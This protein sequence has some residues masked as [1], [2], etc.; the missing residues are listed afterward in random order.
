MKKFRS[1]SDGRTHV[2]LQAKMIEYIENGAKLGWLIDPQNQSVEI[3]HHGKEVEI[4][5]N[6][7]YLSCEDTLPNFI[8]HL[9][10][11]L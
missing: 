7:T 1:F 9:K 2:K 3:Y 10:R 4:L 11:I 6:P 5:E 8:L